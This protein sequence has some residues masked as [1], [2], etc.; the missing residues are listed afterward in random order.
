MSFDPWY[1][2]RW[3]MGLKLGNATRKLILNALTTMA[4]SNTGYCFASQEDLGVY[5]ECSVRTVGTHLR[6]LEANGLI[7]R[8][9]RFSPTGRR[10]AD[11][12]LCLAPG[13]ETWPDGSLIDRPTTGNQA[14]SEELAGGTP[15]SSPSEAQAAEQERP[16]G[17]TKR[18]RKDAVVPER[19]PR[20]QIPDGFPDELRPHAR[21]VLV[22]L[23]E[24]A[25]DHGA[26]K[27]WPQA[28][29]RLIMSQP[30]KPLVATA[31]ELHQ[32]AVDPP[33]K[34]IDVVATYRT[35]LKRA[36][37]LEGPERLATDGTPGA[38]PG[39][40]VHQLR[41]RGGRADRIAANLAEAER[42][43]AELR[44]QGL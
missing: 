29:G 30:R 9:M 15:A 36:Q 5:A 42:L 3:S 34:V 10:I 22:L 2:Q 19:D 41:P 33:R 37:D 38:A 26:K 21:Q 39:G 44:A 16:S 1:F 24:V 18:E 7:A 25:A 27:V 20:E 43:Q 40:N 13:I 4:E 17:T 32:W 28:L 35:F 12:F 31:H 14:P 11:G 6:A 8:R 23:R